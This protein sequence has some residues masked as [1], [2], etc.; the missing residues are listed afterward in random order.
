[1]RGTVVWKKNALMT[2]LKAPNRPNILRVD[3][4]AM[5]TERIAPTKMKS[6]VVEHVNLFFPQNAKTSCLASDSE[7]K[8]GS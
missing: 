5:T 7:V 2:L 6:E 1:M 4:M 3:R 8:S